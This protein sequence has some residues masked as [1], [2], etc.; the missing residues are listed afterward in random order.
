MPETEAVTKT[1]QLNKREKLIEIEQ[2]FFTPKELCE[3][4][5]QDLR[6]LTE[7][8][9]ELYREGE[10]GK[11]L[12]AGCLAGIHYL[13][14]RIHHS[15]GLSSNLDWLSERYAETELLCFAE[16]EEGLVES[17]KAY[18]QRSLRIEPVEIRLSDGSVYYGLRSPIDQ[19]TQDYRRIPQNSWLIASSMS[20]PRL[21]DA[22]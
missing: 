17:R 18:F 3:R 21:V 20:L 1:P 15:A 22:F 8:A 5:I 11:G 4:Y 13:T 12:L 7:A 9:A 16:G 6:R 10:S 19:V 14:D 2:Q